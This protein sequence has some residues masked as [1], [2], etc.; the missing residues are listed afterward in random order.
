MTPM[1][2]HLTRRLL[3]TSR[4]RQLQQKP[5]KRQRLNNRLQVL[6]V[7]KEELRKNERELMSI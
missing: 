2:T 3:L 6:Q 1:M 4:H 7:E 5:R